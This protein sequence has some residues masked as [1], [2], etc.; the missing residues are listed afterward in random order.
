MSDTIHTIGRRKTAVARVFL[1]KGDNDFTIGAKKM[2]AKEYFDRADHLDAILSPLKLLEVSKEFSIH[3]TVK[4]G[5]KSA[6]ADS[7][8]LAVARALVAYEQAHFQ[9]QTASVSE[10]EGEEAPLQ[11]PWRAKLKKE[12]FLTVDSR[13]VER[14][15]FGLKGAR[16]AEQY[17]KR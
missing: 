2:A 6:Q 15:K 8:K 5:G 16:K 12:N 11:N 17:S 10:E 13:R 1:T 7:I 9:P 3:A 14:K 4:G